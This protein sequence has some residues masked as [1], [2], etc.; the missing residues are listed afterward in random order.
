MPLLIEPNGCRNP[1]TPPLATKKVRFVGEP[2]MAV[3]VKEKY[4]LEDIIERVQFEYDLLPPVASA[5]EAMKEDGA[6]LYEEWGE[7]LAYRETVNRGNVEQAFKAAHRVVSGMFEVNRQYGAAMET[8]GAIAD[9]DESGR[10]TLYSSTQWP[11]FV[12]TLLAKTLRYPEN[13]IRVIAP[14]V[15]GGFGN[16]QDFYRE[17][18]VA[19]IMAIKLRRPVKWVA[20]RYED[21]MSTVHAR[22]QVHFGEMAVD[23]D[24]R[25]IGLRD[26][27]IAD[28][29]A[30]GPMS[31]GPEKVTLKSMCGPYMIE[32][33]SLDLGCYVTNKVPVGAYRGFG[34]AEAAFALER[35]IDLAAEEMRMEPA[36]IR[37]KNVV[38]NFPHQNVLGLLLDSGNY[39]EMI[40]RGEEANDL[41][42]FRELQRDHMK[43]N[44]LVGAGF[45]FGLE[46]AGIGPSQLL[47]AEGVMYKGFETMTVKITPDGK[48]KILTGL[49]PHGQGLVTAL[50]Q[51]CADE[52]GTDLENISVEHGDTES[53]PYGFGTWGSRSAV[54]GSSALLKCTKS[55]KEKM[56]RI[57]AHLLGVPEESVTFDSGKYYAMGN[58]EESRS[59]PEVAG[60]AYLKGLDGIEPG[61]EVTMSY[62]PSEL[63][64]TG[65][66]HIAE[67]EVNQETG[68]V[69]I[70]RYIVVHDCGRMINPAI[71]EGQLHGG[72]AQGLAGAML[73]EVVYDRDG[74]LLTPT[75]MDYLVPTAVELP[76]IELLHLE[77]PSP[78]NELGIK[79][80][81]ESGVLA[82]AAAIANAVSD[83]L[84]PL[85]VRV[86][87]TPVA[88][89]WLWGLI[90]ESK[91]QRM[92]VAPSPA[93]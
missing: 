23:R 92:K 64:I 84:R 52:F 86:N 44:R 32:N 38:V 93:S 17:E 74:Q 87:K 78:F 59:V 45:A 2:I 19:S 11:H 70:M 28:I 20:S 55:L 30:Y 7:N 4:D 27:I 13:M 79:G 18:V 60:A 46:A 36:E 1:R 71:V 35:L 63:T 42:H 16:K 67:V 69:S 24:G 26:R 31:L 49:S 22:E 9:C 8:R 57:A 85:G 75:F 47:D 3:A 65:G 76:S 43:Q 61:L 5:E 89:H 39:L 58:P 50:S 73:E 15:G 40:R 56:K 62:E 12:R 68:K 80:M 21:M 14:D 29:G 6:L 72:V 33:I 81:G 91:L 90:R 82:P 48:V 54:V 51:V 34:Q 88:P 53:C 41:N 83:A 25:V 10:L 37:A 66:L 77:T